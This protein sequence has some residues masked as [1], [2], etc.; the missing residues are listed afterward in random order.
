MRNLKRITTE[1]ISAKEDNRSEEITDE[2]ISRHH[3]GQDDVPVER[4]IHYIVKDYRRM[5]LDYDELRARVRRAEQKVQDARDKN[6]EIQ[7]VNERL[8]KQIDIQ[9]DTRH[10]FANKKLV[11]VLDEKLQ[12]ARRQN[13]LL[14]QAVV[15]ENKNYSV[16]SL[17]LGS[18]LADTTLGNQ[19]I[20]QVSRHL[21]KALIKLTE[22]EERLAEYEDTLEK[23]VVMDPQS[24]GK[25]MLLNQIKQAFKDISSST[26]HIEN[27]AKALSNITHEL[28]CNEPEVDA[29]EVKRD[30]KAEF[31]M[32]KDFFVGQDIHGNK[33]VVEKNRNWLKDE[34]L[35]KTMFSDESEGHKNA[36]EIDR[37]LS[38]AMIDYVLQ[39][40][41]SVDSTV[42]AL[43]DFI[44][45]QLTSIGSALNWEK[46][47]VNKVFINLVYKC[48]KANKRK[49]YKELEKYKEE[50]PEEFDGDINSK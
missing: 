30:A 32:S 14:A 26:S 23:I 5:Y 41:P 10:K 6:Y 45:K 1:Q 33:I 27:S 7:K 31:E 38:D 47:E 46:H 42:C 20:G 39:N 2:E 18:A 40:S 12:E 21:E 13:R 8:Q 50:H 44:A 4:L 9:M 25:E 36:V 29:K 22:V 11:N 16:D 19:I 17:S 37:L 48:Q 35:V 28:S 49:F 43:A 3:R 34:N 24:S 15:E